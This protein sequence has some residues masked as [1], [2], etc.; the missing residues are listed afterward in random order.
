MFPRIATT[1]AF[2]ATL[3]PSA[4]DMP[5]SAQ[6]PAQPPPAQPAATPPPITL[7]SPLTKLKPLPPAAPAR[8]GC[9]HLQ[10]GQQQWQ[11][12]PC[13][14]DD[15]IYRHQ[16]PPPVPTNGIQSVPHTPAGTLG[17]SPLS[18]T[19]ISFA[20]Y[21]LVGLEASA[22]A[23][24]TDDKYG[25]NVFS[26][27]NNTN[28]FPCTPCS[29]GFPF[30]AVEG[31]KNSA[32]Q[33]GDQGWI[34]FVYQQYSDAQLLCIWNIDA[35][36]ANNTHGLGSIP[37]GVARGFASSGWPGFHATCLNPPPGALTGPSVS[38]YSGSAEIV[39][40]ISCSPNSNCG[41][42]LMAWLPWTEQWWSIWDVDFVG[43]KGNWTAVTGGVLGAGGRSQADFAN[44]QVQEV[45]QAFSCEVNP[46]A[47][48]PCPSLG[49]QNKVLTLSAVGELIAATSGETNNLVND[50]STFTCEEFG[51]SLW[52]DSSSPP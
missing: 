49:R 21:G 45:L 25:S 7:I 32:S 44:F 27:Q 14:P 42:Q 17:P 37:A 15:F 26:L 28:F 6:Q 48:Q 22:Q 16:L 19:P 8:T 52:W 18:A 12:T 4:A 43:L 24:E 39:G 29:A 36:V 10:D 2:L 41:L 51:C 31:I 50:P 5:A 3:L 23:A 1:A 46:P 38:S 30:A 33:P 35:T 34:Q 11:E 13:A 40:Y 47:A 9:F 20:I